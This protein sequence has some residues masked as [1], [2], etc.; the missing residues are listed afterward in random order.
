[1]TLKEKIRCWLGGHFWMLKSLS[2]NEIKN[3]E[4]NKPLVEYCGYCKKE[5]PVKNET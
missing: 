2:Y 1:M 5:R 4:I 3:G